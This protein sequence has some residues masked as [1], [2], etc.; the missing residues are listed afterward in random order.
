[1]SA[2]FF[3]RQSVISVIMPVYNGLTTINR[4]ISSLSK[5]SY[6]NWELLV[7]DDASTDASLDRLMDWSEKDS[8]IKVLRTDRNLGP[9]AA[10]NEGLR[11]ASGVVITYLVGYFN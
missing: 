8:R 10:R 1:M 5:Q 3:S 2:R 4:S 7:I 9:S 6:S 11:H